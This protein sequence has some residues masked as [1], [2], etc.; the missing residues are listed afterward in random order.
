[1][2][3]P[4]YALLA[5]ASLF[6]ALLLMQELGRRLSRR[7]LD[8][9]ASG[10]AGGNGVVEGVVF[11]LL[12]LL[13]AFTF[14]GA[15]TRFDDRR[16]LIVS[17]VNSIGTAYLRIDLLSEASQPALRER[18]RQ[19]LDARLAAYRALPDLRA[20]RL[21]L[22]R[23][24]GL[25]T[26]IWQLALQSAAGSQPAT[27]LLLPALNEMFDI[28]TTRTAVSNIHPPMVILVFLIA[29]ALLGAMLA[30]FSG[31]AAPRRSW[32]HSVAFAATLT[33]AIYVIVDLEYPRA[34]LIRVDA[35]DAALIELRQGMK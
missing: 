35:F 5:V 26:E 1:M 29:V 15:A 4:L 23:A 25:Q 24:N 7:R 31:A 30:G 6:A 2:D 9:D 32:V 20:A 13:I 17:E 19:Y 10:E 21:E 33:G 16:Q 27:M 11:A 8:R 34:G 14:S 18:F 22:A 28:A 3:H 12:G